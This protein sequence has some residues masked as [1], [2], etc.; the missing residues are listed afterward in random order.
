MLRYRDILL[1]E[2][3][4]QQRKAPRTLLPFHFGNRENGAETLAEETEVQAEIPAM[5]ETEVAPGTPADPIAASTET[6]VYYTFTWAGRARRSGPAAQGG[7]GKPQEAR[8]GKPRGK[9]KPKGADR[10]GKPSEA[11]SYSAKPAPKKDRIDPDN[12]FAAALM[13]FKKDK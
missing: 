3:I 2:T 9:G 10:G 1:P 7:R 5:S 13:G 12:P 11:K 6:E 4:D 8:T